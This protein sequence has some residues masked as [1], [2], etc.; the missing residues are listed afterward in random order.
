MFPFSIPI[1]IKTKQDEKQVYQSLVRALGSAKRVKKRKEGFYELDPD[2]SFASPNLMPDIRAYYK[3]GKVILNYQNPYGFFAM[4]LLTG[5][6]LYGVLKD[7]DDFEWTWLLYY[8]AA[9]VV[10][11]SIFNLLSMAVAVFASAAIREELRKAS[12]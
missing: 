4:V 8:A 7:Y 5:V 9:W 12:P 1:S 6:V 2:I 10:I 11:P 3:P